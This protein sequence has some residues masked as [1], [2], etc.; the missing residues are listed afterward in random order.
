MG[1]FK[2]GKT[3]RRSCI[4]RGTFP[5]KIKKAAYRCGKR[6]TMENEDYEISEEERAWLRNFLDQCIPKQYITVLKIQKYRRAMYAIKKIQEILNDCCK[7]DKEKP[8][9][10]TEWDPLLGTDIGFDAILTELGVTLSADAFKDIFDVLREYDH[11]EREYVISILPRTDGRCYLSI[12]FWNLKE[13][14]AQE[15]G[16]ELPSTFIETEEENEE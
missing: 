15:D 8:T 11:D 14:I 1:L 16:E 9:Y 2:N 12:T 4:N 5:P 3:Q 7:D 13:M 6:K 10:K